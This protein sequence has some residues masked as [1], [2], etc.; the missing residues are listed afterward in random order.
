MLLPL[1]D[2]KWERKEKV[3][4]LEESG[5]DFRGYWTWCYGER[6]DEVEVQKLLEVLSENNL[7]LLFGNMRK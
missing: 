1:A 2:D 7:L 4:W 6:Q 3:V 5:G